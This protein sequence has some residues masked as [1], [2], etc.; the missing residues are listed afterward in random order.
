MIFLLLTNLRSESDSNV[1]IQLAGAKG[2][3]TSPAD[4]NDLQKIWGVFSKPTAF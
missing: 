4:N 2:L 3:P 1:P